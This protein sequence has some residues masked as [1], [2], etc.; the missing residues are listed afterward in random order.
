MKNEITNKQ[1]FKMFVA[2]VAASFTITAFQ[3]CGGSGGGGNAALDYTEA[4]ETPVAPMK[5]EKTDRILHSR[6]VAN[7]LIQGLGVVNTSSVSAEGNNNLDEI[8]KRAIGSEML[9]SEQGEYDSITGGQITIHA[10]NL[11]EVACERMIFHSERPKLTVV[12]GVLKDERR[13][14]KGLYIGDNAAQETPQVPLQDETRYR[15]AIQRLARSL[16]GRDSTKEEEDQIIAGISPILSD[17]K[18]NRGYRAAVVTCTIVA[19]TFDFI[20]Q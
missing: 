20:R 2:I 10:G 12:D 15:A 13:F 17:A 8:F 6:N 7:A 5:V 4:G 11:A 16:W 1:V 14:F 9:L 19:S 18:A 3:N